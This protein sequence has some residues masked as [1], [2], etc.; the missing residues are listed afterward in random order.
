MITRSNCRPINEE[1]E[2]DLYTGIIAVPSHHTSDAAF[3][4]ITQDSRIR[5]LFRHCRQ[6]QAWIR[7]LRGLSWSLDELFS[8]LVHSLGV[9]ANNSV[10]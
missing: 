6:L 5:H 4:E 9:M 8:C 1:Q 3:A 2:L 7:S 10:H